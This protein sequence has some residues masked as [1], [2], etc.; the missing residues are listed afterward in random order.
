MAITR[1]KSEIESYLDQRLLNLE[2]T[3]ASK[4]CI[5]DLKALIVQQNAIIQEQQHRIDEMNNIVQSQSNEINILNDKVAVLNSSVEHL[6]HITDCQEQYS[7]RNCLRIVGIK[8]D[9]DETSD[10]CVEKV[11]GVCKDLNVD[12]AEGCIDRAHRVGRD[13]KTMIV[14]FT[15]FKSRTLLYKSRKKEDYPIKIHLDITKKRLEILDEAKKH[16]KDDC[17][18]NFVFADINCN[19][20][21]KTKD[22]RYLF[23]NSLDEFKKIL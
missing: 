20:V 11:L 4:K 22:N 16:I 1:S 9:R 5:E 2:Q 23:F 8:K 21:A 17:S 13:R 6:K 15:S 14:K 19:T 7:R 12:I 10:Q 3:L 18:V